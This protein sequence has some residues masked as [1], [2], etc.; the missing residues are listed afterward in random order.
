MSYSEDEFLPISGLQ[1][2]AFCPRQCALIHLEQTWSE[3][4]LTALGNIMHERVHSSDAETR[5]DVRTVRGMRLCSRELGLTGVADAVEFHRVESSEEN[6]VKLPR[7]RGLWKPFPV[8]YKRGK[9]KPDNCDS[10]QLCA[11]AMCLEEALQTAIPEAALFYGQTRQRLAVVLDESLR[12]QTRLMAERFH[13]LIHDQKIPAPQPGKRCQ[14]CSLADSCQPTSPC[15][16]RQWI[17]AM[18]E[19]NISEDTR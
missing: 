2:L 13:Q 11:Q 4:I 16:A 9:P 3:N 6:G 15:N 19:R 5:S 17:D 10:V 18:I 14:S 8:E 7:R 12:R 1:H